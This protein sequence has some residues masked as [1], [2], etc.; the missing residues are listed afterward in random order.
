MIRLE[1]SQ[2]ITSLR[3]ENAI[4]LAGIIAVVA[5]LNLNVHHHL[6]RRKRAVT[7]DRT[8]VGIDVARLIAP[9]RI[10]VTGIPEVPAAADKDQPV[11]VA[12][13]P[14]AVVPATTIIPESNVV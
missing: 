6:V 8:I 10:P 1:G 7:V 12:S 4:D 11:I 14:P 2:G 5:E 9:G 13:V 3:S